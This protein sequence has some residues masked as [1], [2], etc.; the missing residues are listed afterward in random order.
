[1]KNKKRKSSIFTRLGAKLSL[2]I[3]IITVS[4]DVLSFSARI[5]IDMIVS[6][7]SSDT[8]N[9]I[10]SVV[11]SIIIGT[12]MSFIVS[13]LFLKPLVELIKATKQV[14]QGD[15]SVQVDMGWAE[16]H[17]VRELSDLIKVFN[18]MTRELNNNAMFNQDFIASFSHEFKTPLVSIRGFAQQL[19]NGNLTPEQQ[20]EFS[21]IILEETEYLSEL[22]T[23][24]L[25]L[26]RL[27]TTDIISKEEFSL[28]E[29]LRT[30]M[31]RLEPH[32]S[33]KN[34]D[35]SM[36][37]D[38][39]KF[40]WNEQMLEH[41]WNNLFDNAV[42]FTP[43]GGSIFVKLPPQRRSHH[44]TRPGYGNGNTAERAPSHIR[45][46]LPGGQLPRHKGQRAGA[47]AGKEDSRG[48]R[49]QDRRTERPRERHGI[50]RDTPR[51]RKSFRQKQQ[52][53]RTQ[54]RRRRINRRAK[55]EFIS[56][57]TACTMISE[58]V[59]KAGVSL[60]N[61]VKYIY[62]IAD[63]DFYNINIKDIF[64]IALNNISDTTCLYNTGIK[65][66]KERCAE[67]NTPEY[68]RVLSLMVYSFAV[69]LP[70]LKNVKTSGGYLNDK[71]IKTIYDMVISKGAGNYDNV[72]ADD[73]EEI[74][75]MV[76]SGKPVPAYDAEW[77][78]GYIY[79]YVPTLA[80]ITNKN[81]FLL[82][83]ADILFTLFYSCLEEELVR[84]LNSL[85]A[86]A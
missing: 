16:K 31:L 26:T 53:E 62:M 1:M 32:W 86:Q 20:K 77:Y 37:L 67:M 74:R 13:G 29:Q 61:A 2:L 23:N 6:N 34:I 66:D 18:E 83:S 17:T 76:K 59:V 63:K 78:K 48:V 3:L 14:S 4:A 71:Q 65:L 19:Y 5:S 69:R 46:I 82:G 75:R 79:T 72:I 80:A 43:E 58:T 33:E 38:E 42:K 41:V 52:P 55:M 8:E 28:D 44:D 51:R 47:S 36:E 40:F 70:V 9:I 11:S 10:A 73:F 35:L 30:C 39:V 68:E 27:E 7:G 54:P 50:H 25:L 57:R 84:L 49:R 45:E 56:E 22:S 24:T 15:Y 60:F 81:V 21:K 12:L 64:K 85:A